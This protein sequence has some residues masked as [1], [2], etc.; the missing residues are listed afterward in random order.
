MKARILRGQHRSG[1]PC[2]K[3]LGRQPL[4]LRLAGLH[5]PC[6]AA[7]IATLEADAAA[8]ELFGAEP[9]DCNLGKLQ[10]RMR[11]QR[12][13]AE[14]AVALHGAADLRR[15][16][17]GQ[18]ITEHAQQLRQRRC[19]QAPLHLHAGGCERQRGGGLDRCAPCG[20]VCLCVCVP[21][22]LGSGW[23]ACRRTR[24]RTH[25]LARLFSRLRA[26]WQVH[27]HA[28]H[29]IKHVV[30]LHAG[31]AGEPQLGGRQRQ[32]ARRHARIVE[33]ARCAAHQQG[34]AITAEAKGA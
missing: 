7:R 30:A 6:G 20:Q 31:A 28:E 21:V 8:G 26:R 29:R 9:R 14:R 19:R 17:L 12:R 23:F 11:P 2:P 15:A 3:R 33:A 25:Q 24:L 1:Q 10:P 5:L 34:V 32:H 16:Q 13:Q 27:L 4:L 18:T 22:L